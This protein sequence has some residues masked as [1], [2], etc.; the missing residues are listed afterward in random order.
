MKKSNNLINQVVNMTKKNDAIYLTTDFRGFYNLGYFSNVNLFFNNFFNTLKK[1]QIVSI[2]PSYTYTDKGNFYIDKTKSNL[3]SL[4]KWA[5][6][7][8]IF[9]R[10]SHP[11]FSVLISDK[12]DSNLLKIGKSAF[13]KKSIFD[14][15]LKY[16]SALVHIGRPVENGNTVIHYIEQMCGAYYRH[17]KTFSTKVFNK[18]KYIG[19]NYSVYVRTINNKNH[20]ISNT[21]RIAKKLKE[22]KIVNEV[23]NYK[24]LTNIS[25]LNFSQSVDFMVDEFYKNNKVFI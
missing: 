10:T 3:G 21:K 17:N 11:M 18:N 19:T 4:T 24:N 22:K 20:Y 25:V 9:N 8:Q 15:L 2:I 14:N 23:G 13:G 7:S 1:K 12:I 6:D 5:F 16:N